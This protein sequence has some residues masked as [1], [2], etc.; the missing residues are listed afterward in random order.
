MKKGP[1]SS[2]SNSEYMLLLT[3]NMQLGLVP[4]KARGAVQ[5]YFSCKTK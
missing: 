5:F 3:P 1:M 2:Y 4:R